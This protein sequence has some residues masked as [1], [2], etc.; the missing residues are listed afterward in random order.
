MCKSINRARAGLSFLFLSAKACFREACML[1]EHAPGSSK[2][3]TSTCQLPKNPPPS[4]EVPRHVSHNTP[5]HPRCGNG[6][7]HTSNSNSSDGTQQQQHPPSASSLPTGCCTAH[8]CARIN[9]QVN[10]PA[11]KRSS[12]STS[13]PLRCVGCA[14]AAAA[15]A[16]LA[17]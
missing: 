9:K 4:Q 12:Y 11:E 8:V 7:A 16:L 15:G 6:T 13:P 3:S 17:A 14:A 10:K 2:C 1:A 5:P